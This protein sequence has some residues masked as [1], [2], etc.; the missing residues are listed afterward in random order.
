MTININKEGIVLS[1]DSLALTHA[2]QIY[3]DINCIRLSNKG[4]DSCNTDTGRSCRKVK[5]PWD[6]ATGHPIKMRAVMGL[7]HLQREHLALHWIRHRFKFI[8][9][10]RIKER[11]F[12]SLMSRG[13][14]F[15]E[16][17]TPT[18]EDYFFRGARTQ[19]R[20]DCYVCIL[21]SIQLPINWPK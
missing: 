16:P 9:V 8:A 1:E 3:L 18:K 21:H 15:P 7:V 14:F 10:Q 4:W 12:A 11:Q 17:L 6:K 19:Q 2:W 5:R 13:F 20:P